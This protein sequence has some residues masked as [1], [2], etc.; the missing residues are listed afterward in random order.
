MSASREKKK[1]ETTLFCHNFTASSVELFE[2]GEGGGVWGRVEESVEIPMGQRPFRA[3][4][5]SSESSRVEVLARSSVTAAAPQTERQKHP[6][7]R[8]ELRID[9]G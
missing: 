1:P 4:G 2:D 6:S 8:P 7:A 5:R 3:T 9:W